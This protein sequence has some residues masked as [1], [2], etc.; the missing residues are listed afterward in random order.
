MRAEGF[1]AWDGLAG[2][3]GCHIHDQ[4]GWASTSEIGVPGSLV[5]KVGASSDVK[6]ERPGPRVVPRHV[7]P[8][9]AYRHTSL[10]VSKWKVTSSDLPSPSGE[11]LW[12]SSHKYWTRL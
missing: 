7:G 1:S 11:E 6:G 8:S 2:P 10:L 4:P 3:G 12:Y 5:N 9:Q